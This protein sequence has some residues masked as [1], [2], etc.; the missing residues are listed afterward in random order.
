MGILKT[1]I[2]PILLLT[3]AILAQPRV[4]GIAVFDNETIEEWKI[5]KLIRTSETP[6]YQRILGKKEFFKP[7]QLEKDLKIIEDYYRSDGF[8]DVEV[9]ANAHFDES[10]ECV[11][12]NIFIDEGMRYILDSLSIDGVIPATFSRQEIIEILDSHIGEPIDPASLL[13]DER[14]I[15]LFMQKRGHPY[16]TAV[17]DYGKLA[18]NKAYARYTIDP[19][20]YA[21]FGDFA[22]AGLKL[23]NNRV[24]ERELKFWRGLPFDASKVRGSRESLYGTG[25]F[26]VVAME[27]SND[28]LQPDT[29]D[30]NITIVEKAPRWTTASIGA[31]SDGTYDFVAQLGASWGHRNLFGTGRE[32]S[33]DFSSD[34]KLNT[35]GDNLGEILGQWDN[36]GNRIDLKFVEP[37][38]FGRKIPIT[39]NPYYE[40]GNSTEIPQYT[41]QLVG[42]NLSASQRPSNDLSHTVYLTFEIADIYDVRDP[43][44]E[45]QIFADQDQYFTRSIGYSIVVDRRDNLLVPTEGYY[46]SGKTELAG[47][48]LGGDKSYTKLIA[49]Y[50]RYFSFRER[51]V[52]ALRGKSSVLGNW[53]KGEYVLIHDRFFLG[54]ANSVRGWRERSIG[55]ESSSG[56][57]LGGKLSILGNVE[58]RSPI[59]WQLWGHAFFDVGNVWDHAEAFGIS[60]FRGSAGW[61]LAIITPVGPIRFDYGYQ[62]LNRE[63]SSP[64]SNWHLSLMYAF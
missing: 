58:L 60:D 4:C 23:T 6:W 22:I 44:L 37:Y 54:G 51:M 34:W 19:N 36:L 39:L 1:K 43:E 30:Y 61:G 47:Y 35:S 53:R 9:N 13:S 52:L 57:P 5:K 32:L 41:M 8:L 15:R 38:T 21:Y 2:L 40:P 56:D 50:R 64:N 18:D 14:K 33:V 10:G 26:S 16:A 48:F 46:F 25:L 59:I 17:L 63:E 29:I 12:I 28:S 7:R 31:G 27:P 20:K 11:Y 3:T 45:E 49:D 55:P 24:V 42:V 62:I